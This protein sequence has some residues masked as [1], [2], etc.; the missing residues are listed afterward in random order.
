MKNVRIDQPCSENWNQMLPTEKGAFCQQCAAEVIDFT[1]KSNAEIKE[2]LSGLIGKPVCSRMKVSQIETLHAEVETWHR[3]SS[4]QF[5]STLLLSLVLVFGLSLFSCSTQKEKETILKMQETVSEVVH[6]QAMPAAEVQDKSVLFPQ[7]DFPVAV[8]VAEDF[9]QIY[10]QVQKSA[11]GS[12]STKLNLDDFETVIMG[13]FGWSPRFENFLVEDT[14]VALTEYD[15]NG[16]EIPKV[17]LSKAY[18]NP[19]SVDTKLEIGLPED[20]FMEINLYDMNGRLIQPVFSGN[21]KR[22]THAYQVDV[23]E[24]P[25]GTYLFSIR[26]RLYSEAVRVLKI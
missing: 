18:P 8:P 19:A 15:E 22:G 23:V 9:P 6:I 14:A 13:G 20:D 16:I 26:G 1:S 25:A 24:L 11:P 2:I 12:G 4:H 21:L 5:Q 7:Q 10:H 3:S 17:F